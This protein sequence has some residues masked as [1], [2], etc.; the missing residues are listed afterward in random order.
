MAR[1]EPSCSQQRQRARRGSGRTS[2][3]KH[4]NIQSRRTIQQLQKI[5]F[6][7]VKVHT[8]Q[9]AK[10]AIHNYGH[11]NN[12]NQVFLDRIV[13]K[14]RPQSEH[15]QVKNTVYTRKRFCHDQCPWHSEKKTSL[16]VSHLHG[17]GH[18]GEG[19]HQRAVL[20]RGVRL[21]HRVARVAAAA[22]RAALVLLTATVDVARHQHR[23]LQNLKH[24]ER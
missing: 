15:N 4:K 23:H 10:S 21:A 16:L 20:G 8:K 19:V 13:T 3:A 2:R 11:Q 24:H 1:H 5:C 6:A 12:A 17:G 22:P 7:H 14:I 9:P 18:F